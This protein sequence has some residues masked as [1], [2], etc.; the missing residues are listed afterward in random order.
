MKVVYTGKES[1]GKSL[2]LSMEAQEILERNKKWLKVT[3]I[4]R[5]M[6]FNTPMSPEFIKEIKEA[7]II[8]LEWRNLIDIL[9]LTEADV[10]IDELI[11]YFPA[12][13]S[14]SLSREQ[15]D[16]IT[17][18]AKTGIHI[19]GASQDFSQVHK[20]FR[21][22]VNE[23]YIVTKIIG[24]PRPMKTA[25]PVKKIWGVCMTRSVL[26]SSFKGDSATMESK[27]LIP[28]FFLIRQ[29]DTRRFDT[30][31]KVPLT[32]LPLKVVREQELVG[33]AEDG[34]TVKYKKTMWI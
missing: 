32:K 28:S 1:S 6:A 26:P 24:S 27:D 7:G 33:Y 8:Y 16:F 14:N 10:F 30:S 2:K 15:L 21:L 11:K 12:S 18:G 17:Q 29:K 31:Y 23:V 3:G 4:P 22:L 9:H 25:P 5:T 20:Q 19:I 13:G 34:K